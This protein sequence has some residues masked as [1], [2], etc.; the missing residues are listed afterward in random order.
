MENDQTSDIRDDFDFDN[1]RS[2]DL[3]RQRMERFFLAHLH[4]DQLTEMRNQ[5]RELIQDYERVISKRDVQS[6]DKT[7]DSSVSRYPRM[8]WYSSSLLW[9]DNYN[10]QSAAWSGHWKWIDF[11]HSS[12]DWNLGFESIN[13]PCDDDGVLFGLRNLEQI[14][15]QC[16]T[17]FQ[18]Q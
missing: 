18:S 17:Q 8:G 4:L 9:V 16:C 13:E 6:K 2:E 14:L 10:S 15:N 3:Y 11:A 12:C 7:T 5:C 1:K